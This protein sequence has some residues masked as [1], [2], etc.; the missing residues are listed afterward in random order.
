MDC[1]KRNRIWLRC[2][3]CKR[4]VNTSK[5]RFGRVFCLVQRVRG[6]EEKCSFDSYC[7]GAKEW[8]VTSTKR[9]WLGVE[10]EERLWLF[11]IGVVLPSNLVRVRI[12]VGVVVSDVVCCLCFPFICSHGEGEKKRMRIGEKRRMCSGER[13]ESGSGSRD[14][15][16]FKWVV[17]F[18]AKHRL[19]G[20]F[21]EVVLMFVSL[22]MFVF[23]VCGSAKQ[24]ANECVRW[25]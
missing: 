13:E 10:R 23:V 6:V 25:G 7:P 16:W 3:R 17:S 4:N 9:E 12:R 14:W 22:L 2:V 19:P 11:V 20:C 1:Y 21:N 5:C 24:L 8:R 18:T 15:F